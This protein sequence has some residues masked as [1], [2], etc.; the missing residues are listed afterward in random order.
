LTGARRVLAVGN[1][2]DHEV[3]A[4]AHESAKKNNFPVGF[5]VMIA[6]VAALFLTVLPA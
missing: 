1:R 4:N 6:M 5:L 3:Q 2:E